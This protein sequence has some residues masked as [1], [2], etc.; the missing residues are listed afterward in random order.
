MTMRYL[1]FLY[2]SFFLLSDCTR[3]IAKWIVVGLE[4]GEKAQGDNDSVNM[5]RRSM[6]MS[7][8][9]RE[10]EG[11]GAGV[12]VSV[13]VINQ[14]GPQAACLSQEHREEHRPDQDQQQE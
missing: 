8:T 12:G 3:F 2:W 7:S 5:S 9:T 1:P 6:N 13:S 10:N 11:N 4:L 14:D